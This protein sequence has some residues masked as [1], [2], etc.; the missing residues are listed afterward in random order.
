[1]TTEEREV[2]LQGRRERRQA[3]I[4]SERADQDTGINLSVDDHTVVQRMRQF[5]GR[6]ATLERQSCSICLE[7]FTF[8]TMNEAGACNRC[9]TDRI[10]PKLYSAANNMDPGPVTAELTVSLNV[11]THRMYNFLIYAHVY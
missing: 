7:H 3:T 6:L 4:S 11:F 1:M 8:K 5:H 2:V 10:V 9:H